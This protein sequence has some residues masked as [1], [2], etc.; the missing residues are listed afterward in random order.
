MPTPS[1][2]KKTIENVRGLQSNTTF[3]ARSAA[4][5]SANHSPKAISLTGDS[6][7]EASNINVDPPLSSVLPA[8]SSSEIILLPSVS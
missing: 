2:A 1:G 3:F 7:I 5:E 6:H 8:L 4:A